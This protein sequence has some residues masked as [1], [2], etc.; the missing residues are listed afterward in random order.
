MKEMKKYFKY[1][2]ICKALH[3]KKMKEGIYMNVC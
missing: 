2:T 1:V 3:E